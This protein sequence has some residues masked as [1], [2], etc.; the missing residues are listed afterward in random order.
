MGD[1]GS[2]FHVWFYPRP[3]GVLQLRGTF[4]PVWGMTMDPLPEPVVDAAAS[5]VA[6]SLAVDSGRAVPRLS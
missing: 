5:R 4:L 1:G 6:E 3:Y 2:H